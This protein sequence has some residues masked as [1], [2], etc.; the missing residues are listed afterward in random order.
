MRIRD[1]AEAEEKQRK[2]E[3][4]GFVLLGKHRVEER[5]QVSAGNVNQEYSLP[6]QW[7]RGWIL[8]CI[9]LISKSVQLGQPF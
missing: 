9:A 4:R 8:I 3:V 5:S 1:H 2:E 7:T 6:G